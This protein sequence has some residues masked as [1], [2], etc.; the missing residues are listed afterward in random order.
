MQYDFL[1]TC[2]DGTKISATHFGYDHSPLVIISSA[3]GTDRGFYSK[4]SNYLVDNNFQ[5]VTFDYRGIG[6]SRIK[7]ESRSTSLSSWGEQD[8]TAVIDWAA[9]KAGKNNLTLVG[10]SIAGQIFPLAKNKDLVSAAYFVASQTA[11]SSYWSGTYKLSIKLFWN[12]M[13][14]AT[15][16][17]TGSL[18][19]WTYGGKQ[20]LPKYVAKE[21]AQ[22]G[23]HR[24]GVLQDC[25]ARE[26]QFK[27]VQIPLRF[28]SFSDDKL[29][30]PR[31]AVER[32]A[33]QY[34]STQKEHYHWY[35]DEFGKKSIGHFGFFR[36]ANADLWEDLSLW[37]SR[38]IK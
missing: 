34:G 6:E 14:P 31:A 33:E 37:L 16:T 7:K 17:L 30:A 4:F 19:A 8:L 2:E 26:K 15:T 23:R 38:H 20:K 24:N 11:S 29:F 36:S 28:V 18:P 3:V 25:P 32:L 27:E 9:A 22:W 21:W 5:V 35:P 10:H 1:V 12:L 13:L